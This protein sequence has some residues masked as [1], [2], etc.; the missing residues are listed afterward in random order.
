[1]D[2]K[3]KIAK[4][5]REWKSKKLKS[6]SGQTVRSKDQALAIALNEASKYRK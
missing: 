4:V 2:K 6:S 3:S 1:M 5:M